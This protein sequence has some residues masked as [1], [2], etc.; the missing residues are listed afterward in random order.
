M[1]Y[2]YMLTL[3]QRNIDPYEESDI[4][5]LCFP[6]S[7]LENAKEGAKFSKEWEDNMEWM[8]VE[9]TEYAA[10]TTSSTMKGFDIQRKVIDSPFVDYHFEEG[11]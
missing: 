9:S 6:Y 8:T 3:Y 1:T 4:I 10:S 2:V 5:G 11:E 7:S